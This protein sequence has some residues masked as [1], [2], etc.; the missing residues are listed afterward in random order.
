MQI[1]KDEVVVHSVHGVGTVVGFEE[2][3]YNGS[4]PRKYCVI[5]I[6]NGTVWVPYDDPDNASIRAIPSQ[7]DLEEGRERLKSEPAVFSADRFKRTQE[8]NRRMKN[9]A[10]IDLVDLVRDLSAHGWQGKTM[11]MDNT[12]LRRAM[13]NLTQEW[14]LSAGTSDILAGAEIRSLL[15][16]CRDQY[17]PAT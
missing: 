10:F 5:K 2:M 12:A 8:L 3:E 14:A 1:A 6:A 9:P 4:K 13:E 16:I 7:E 11:D 15:Q 17:A